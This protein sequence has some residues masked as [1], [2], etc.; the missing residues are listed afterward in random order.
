M[1]TIFGNVQK[2]IS[3]GDLAVNFAIDKRLVADVIE[4]F[5]YSVCMF[6]SLRNETPPLLQDIIS[7]CETLLEQVDKV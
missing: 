7:Y 3:L 5:L 1:P 4:K 6:V 2:N